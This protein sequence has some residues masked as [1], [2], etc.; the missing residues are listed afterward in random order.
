MEPLCNVHTPW[1]EHTEDSQ[2]QWEP[3]L[4]D[5]YTGPHG[6]ALG[7]GPSVKMK[8]VVRNATSLAD[9][10][11]GILPWRF[12]KKCVGASEEYVYKDYVTKEKV[13]GRTRPI[14]KHW[15][16]SHPDKYHRADKERVKFKITTC[17]VL[18]WIAIRIIQGAHFVSYKPPARDFW[19]RPPYGISLP[20]TKNSMNLEAFQFIRRYFHPSNSKRQVPKGN[21]GHDPLFKI[22]FVLVFVLAGMRAAWVADKHVTIDESMIKYKGKY[23]AFV[24]YM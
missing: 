11:L 17:F 4:A 9:V 22:R 12:W 7:L 23:V 8:Q 18:A 2:I 1:L 15:R 13:P 14:M 3:D 24:Q 16:T 10:F 19:A 20:S 21:V 6:G 5:Q